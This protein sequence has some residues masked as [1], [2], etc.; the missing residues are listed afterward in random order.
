MYAFARRYIIQIADSYPKGCP[1]ERT[2]F[3]QLLAMPF[4]L[5]RDGVVAIDDELPHAAPVEVV[6][7][8]NVIGI[9]SSHQDVIVVATIKARRSRKSRA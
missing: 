6:A 3:L 8:G 2:F 1:V 9:P 7:R 5:I 4:W